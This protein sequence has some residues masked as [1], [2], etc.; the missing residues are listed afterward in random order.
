MKML[1]LRLNLRRAIRLLGRL[2]RRL[3][4]DRALELLVLVVVERLDVAA[5]LARGRLDDVRLLRLVGREGI[6]AELGV[7][8]A[9]AG[10]FARVGPVFGEEVEKA[11]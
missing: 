4:A 5:V 1:Y 7:G 3:L 11:A 9:G 6:R 2:F 8:P 10:V